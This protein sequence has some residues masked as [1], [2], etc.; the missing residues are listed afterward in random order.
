MG[1]TEEKKQKI[2][3]SV[4]IAL[5]RCYPAEYFSEHHT[6]M[7]SNFEIWTCKE[8]VCSIVCPGRVFS[9]KFD[10]QLNSVSSLSPA[11]EGSGRAVSNMDSGGLIR[12]LSCTRYSSARSPSKCLGIVLH[13]STK[14]LSSC[15]V[16]TLHEGTRETATLIFV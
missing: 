14:S 8:H 7:S 10:I 12:L 5:C 16:Y 4:R 6:L 2:L 9:R 1:P 13:L 11:E 15:L 3:K